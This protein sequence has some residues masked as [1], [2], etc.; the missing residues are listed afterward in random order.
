MLHGVR[1]KL[2]VTYAVAAL[3]V[4]VLMGFGS[5]ALL[6]HYF[7]SNT[8]EALAFRMAEEFQTTFDSLPPEL[9]QAK[10]AWAAHHVDETKD[11]AGG[12][13]GNSPAFVPPGLARKLPSSELAPLYTVRL[14]TQG[15]PLL[16]TD[17]EAPPLSADAVEGRPHPRAR[18]PHDHHLRR[19][20]RACRDLRCF[21]P[22]KG[23]DT[24]DPAVGVAFIQVGRWLTDQ[25]RILSQLLTSV[26][27]LCAASAVVVGGVSWW[28]SGR[29]I[30]PA[31]I[32]W[33]KQRELVANAGHELRTPITLVRAAAEV[34]RR[35][36]RGAADPKKTDDLLGEI[37]NET[38]HLTKLTDDLVLLS[39]LDSGHIVF[40]KVA[41]DLPA[42]LR[43]IAV[44]FGR[45]CD[46]RGVK[47][48]VGSTEGAI[49]ADPARVRQTIAIALDN[50]M[51]FTPP[52]GEIAL[53]T[54]IRDRWVDISVRDTGAGI[55]EADLE[56]V[57]ERFYQGPS[58]GGDDESRH[59]GLG[60][61]IARAVVEGQ[62]GRLTLASSVG[63]GTTLTL[64]FPAVAGP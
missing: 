20:S 51:R 64:S 41:I 19:S 43:D 26:L 42:F 16:A 31:K 13:P 44:G 62:G 3:C 28:F 52:G 55:A 27:V 6:V 46:E 29:S 30:R 50:A 40:S 61:A 1:V 48:L 2:T 58:P 17:E 21:R 25:D 34:A 32:A 63:E 24:K 49:V 15:R 57:F 14:D 56:R 45:L 12:R 23:S 47:L 5:Y 11:D 39:R 53:E 8:D 37:L 54:T 35:E 60:L 4:T 7:E 22:P 59:S 10:S 33:E 36:L 9:A 18:H 38:D